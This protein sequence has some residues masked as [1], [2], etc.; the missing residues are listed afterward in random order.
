MV[1]KDN[2]EFIQIDFI[3][4]L[5]LNVTASFIDKEFIKIKEGKFVQFEM[6]KNN[7]IFFDE[8]K[9]KFKSKKF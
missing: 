1:K 9:N 4:N 3:D 8:K 6:K 2:N 7:L 5:K